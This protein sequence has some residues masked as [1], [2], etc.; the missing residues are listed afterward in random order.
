M[1]AIHSAQMK[2]R[3][4]DRSPIW[5]RL[6]SLL[7]GRLPALGLALIVVMALGNL[8]L[9]RQLNLANQ[10][11]TSTMRV[12]TLANT[13]DSPQ[14]VGTLVT[15]QKGNYGTLVV[16][17]LARL[18]SS[19]QYQVWLTQDGK[20]ISGGVFSVNPDGYASLEILAPLPLI[21]YDAIGITIEPSG[22]SLGPTG[23]KVLGGAILQ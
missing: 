23:A 14:A 12:I 3:T 20:C 22:G 2:T 4:P 9:F 17:N 8:L 7:R 1:G 16:D 6:E 18:D 10:R 15:D 19:R 5:Q 13:K 11:S 21:Q